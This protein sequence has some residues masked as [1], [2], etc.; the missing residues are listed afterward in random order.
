VRR[1]YARNGSHVR[2]TPKS[3]DFDRSNALMLQNLAHLGYEPPR[4]LY[5]HGPKPGDGLD[6][7]EGHG[8]TPKGARALEGTQVGENTRSTS[9][10]DTAYR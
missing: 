3:A 9:G 2:E 10:V 1:Q 4:R 5:V 7:R 8:R 6:R